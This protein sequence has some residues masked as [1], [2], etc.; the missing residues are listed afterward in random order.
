MSGS[1]LSA[2]APRV[3]HKRREV[4]YPSTTRVDCGISPQETKAT[5]LRRAMSVSSR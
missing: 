3:K 2:H 1:R 5:A 4:W